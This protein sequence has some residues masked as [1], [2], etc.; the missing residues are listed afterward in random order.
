MKDV[1][2][3]FADIDG[4][5]C[6]EKAYYAYEQDKY[7]SALR[8]WDPMAVMLIDRICRDYNM[9]VV[10]S[11]TW[12]ILHDVPTILQTYGFKGSFHRM[13]KTPRKRM[14][15]EGR[16]S[17]IQN[18]LDEHKEQYPDENIKKILIIDDQES[19]WQ[20]Y[21][22]RGDGT[23]HPLKKYTVFCDIFEGFGYGNYLRSKKLLEQDY[24]A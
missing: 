22:K 14:S 6:C 9:Q 8:A 12:R 7:R 1:N 13:D 19:G 23:D 16:G 3:L 4:P 17:E 15:N 18:W 24:K 20:L 2:I 11:S 5:I 21:E 10:I